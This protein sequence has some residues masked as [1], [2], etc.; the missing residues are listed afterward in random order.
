MSVP[1]L[2]EGVVKAE[3]NMNGTK[4]E[5]KKYSNANFKVSIIKIIHKI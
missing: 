1:R 4:K 3:S 2:R 5:E